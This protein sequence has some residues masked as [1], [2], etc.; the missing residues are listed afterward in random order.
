MDT[1]KATD[2]DTTTTHAVQKKSSN[3]VNFVVWKASFPVAWGACTQI[4]ALTAVTT[5]KTNSDSNN[6]NYYND[7]KQIQ[8]ATQIIVKGAA[9]QKL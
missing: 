9:T 8:M 1:A 4:A 3:I 7:N 5:A 2:T 6:N